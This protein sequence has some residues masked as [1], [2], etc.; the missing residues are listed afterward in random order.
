MHNGKC[1]CECGH[2]SLWTIVKGVGNTKKWFLT[3]DHLRRW[4]ASLEV[5]DGAWTPVAQS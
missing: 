5:G 3:P 4:E 1:D 2:H